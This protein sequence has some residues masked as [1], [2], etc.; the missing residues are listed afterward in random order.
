MMVVH[1]E[2]YSCRYNKPLHRPQTHFPF[3]LILSEIIKT[4]SERNKTVCPLIACIHLD[5]ADLRNK[6]IFRVKMDWTGTNNTHVSREGRENVDGLTH[7]QVS[8]TGIGLK[9]INTFT[10]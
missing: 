1:Y 7:C 9:N 3:E 5:N 10:L 6:I 2:F 8:Y 4:R